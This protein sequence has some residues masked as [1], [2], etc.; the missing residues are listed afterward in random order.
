MNKILVLIMLSLITQFF[1]GSSQANVKTYPRQI[2]LSGNVFHFSLPEDFSKDMPAYDMVEALDISDPQKFDDPEYGNLIRRWWDIK[3]PGWFGKNLGTV[4]MDISVQ[5]VVENK[6]QLLHSNPYHIK[7]RMDFML[8]L[9]DSF[10]Q[11]YDAL[12]KEIA[13]EHGNYQAY[14][15]SPFTLS[16]RKVISMYRDFVFNEQK[17]IESGMAAPRGELIADYSIPLAEHA[18]LK[19]SFTYSQNAN[20]LPLEFRRGYAYSKTEDILKSFKMDYTKDNPFAKIVGEDWLTQTNDEVLE[21]HR[22]SILQLFY[23]PDPEA[24][25]LKE[26]QEMREADEKD[27][28]EMQELLKHDPL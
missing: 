4:M 10:H 23:G 18:Y 28:R 12:N 14:H 5:R 22:D 25:M 13:P 1:S 20:V 9:D 8:M 26:E 27:Q 6:Q 3:E 17:W 15:S 7:N 21:Q 16:G 11:N 2:N 24:A 19:V